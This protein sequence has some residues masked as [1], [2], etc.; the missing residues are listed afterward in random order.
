MQCMDA[1]SVSDK[2]QDGLMIH[3][4]CVAWCG[5]CMELSCLSFGVIVL[6]MVSKLVS[7]KLCR[8]NSRTD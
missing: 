4:T 2:E 5:V 6:E 1:A 7:V 8:S 3:S